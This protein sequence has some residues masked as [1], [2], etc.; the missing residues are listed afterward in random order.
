MVLASFDVKIEALGDL[1]LTS[2]NDDRAR[3]L[4]MWHETEPHLL[5]ITAQRL[6][7]DFLLLRSVRVENNRREQRETDDE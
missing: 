2:R 1:V 3:V 4:R 7:R 6:K 5:E